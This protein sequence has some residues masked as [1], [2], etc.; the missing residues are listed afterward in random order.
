MHGIYRIVNRV[1]GNQY[2][3]SS[4]NI[5]QRWRSH[6]H[7]LR[8]GRHHSP[9][10]Q[11]AWFKYGECS[12]VFEFLWS[13]DPADLI[14]EE[15]LCFNLLP[16]EYNIAM[17]AGAPVLGRCHTKESKDKMS[18][19][20]RGKPLSAETRARMSVAKR[21]MSDETKER[22]AAAQRM[23]S[24][25]TYIKIRNSKLGTHHS[26]ETIAKMS[27]SHKGRRHS[28]ETRMKMAEARKRFHQSKRSCASN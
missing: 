10:L 3:G 18:A 8:S 20:R 22:M 6:L 4:H 23:R 9:H 11:A 19:A 15:Q 12:F 7:R 17:V 5:K 2:I 14:I 16:C 27:A 28:A 24:H 26:D 13:C 25:D 21:Q 1:N